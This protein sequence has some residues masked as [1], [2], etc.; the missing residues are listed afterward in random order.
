MKA[1]SQFKFIQLLKRHN[2]DTVF[3]VLQPCIAPFLLIG[4]RGIEFLL[5]EGR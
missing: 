2:E 5:W 3:G 1:G 4:G